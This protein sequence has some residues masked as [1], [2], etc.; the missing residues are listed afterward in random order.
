ME[1]LFSGIQ[2]SGNLHLGNYLGAIKQWLSLQDQYEAFFCVVDM[3]AIT[4]P[5]DPAELR[6]K[7]IEIAKVYLAA[8]IDP[9]KST[10]FVQS[11]VSG[12]AEL[13]WVLNTIATMGELNRMTQFKDKTG[14]DF[15]SLEQEM[16]NMF[17]STA[18]SENLFSKAPQEVFETMK[19]V[20]ATFSRMSM[21]GFKEKFGQSQVGLFDY[22][23][24]MAADILLYD[25]GVVPVGEDQKQH[26]ELTRDLAQR[27]NT[28]FGE[29]FVVPEPL[30]QKEG[31]RIMGLDDPTKKMSKSAASEYNSI[32][33]SDD[34]DT[35][36]KKIKKAVTDSGS[37]IIYADDKPA[38]KN[39]INIHTLLSGK[40]VDEVEA[41]YVGKGYGDFKAD[42]AEV[43]VNFLMPFQERFA[44]ISD[45][46]VMAVL[47]DG[48]VKARALSE[49][50]IREV[51]ETVGFVR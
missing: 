32:A 25:T 42:L 22:P 8:G 21:Q 41:M 46:E 28:R 19:K 5:Q 26:V 23:V 45:E 2:P 18:T 33:L 37:E 34:A 16:E 13:A 43:V 51:Y 10:L 35:I 11:H 4:V 1:R 6:Q 48:A 17:M 27:F 39:L 9:K 15:E 49:K 31:A 7:T 30:I 3:H 38:L 50:K 36:R 20:A 44:A 40:K 24:L 29:T 12:H 14:V 47:K